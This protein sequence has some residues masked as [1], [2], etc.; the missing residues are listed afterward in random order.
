ML[1]MNQER[2]ISLQRTE[3]ILQKYVIWKLTCLCSTI[4]CSN[5]LS[6]Y[7]NEKKRSIYIY[8]VLLGGG[9]GGGESGVMPYI[10]IYIY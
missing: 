4:W 1:E 10:Y 9:G 8:H 6:S 7:E 2:T 5:S 3:F